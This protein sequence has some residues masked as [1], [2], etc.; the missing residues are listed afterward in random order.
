[1]GPIILF[2]FGAKN[3][4][5][6]R[7]VNALCFILD[8]PTDRMWNNHRLNMKSKNIIKKLES[9]IDKLNDWKFYLE[10]NSFF[11]NFLN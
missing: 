3:W 10:D 2:S 7:V 4:H 9:R 6:H 5:F 8:Q 11:L 1:M